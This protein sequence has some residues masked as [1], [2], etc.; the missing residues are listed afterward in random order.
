MRFR[1]NGSR[2]PTTLTSLAG[3]EPMLHEPVCDTRVVITLRPSLTRH[4]SVMTSNAGI[5]RNRR[6]RGLT[7]VRTE[8]KIAPEVAAAIN[9]A[10]KAS[11]DLSLSLYIER[12]V[13]MLEAERGSLPVLSPT[14]DIAEAQNT[15]AA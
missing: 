12:L 1:S 15:E 4:Y 9:A 3:R 11:G 2:H 10:R 5:K 14:L 7:V 8:M 13:S 6:P